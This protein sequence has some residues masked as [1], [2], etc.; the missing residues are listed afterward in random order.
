MGVC[1]SVLVGTEP[2]LK[3]MRLA[4]KFLDRI[5]EPARDAR[6]SSKRSE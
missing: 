2:K 4:N 5:A 1:I 6:G 3:E